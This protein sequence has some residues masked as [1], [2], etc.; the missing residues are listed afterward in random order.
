MTVPPATGG[1]HPFDVGLQPERTALAWRRTA[2]SLAGATVIGVRIVPE[3]AGA[4]T[5][6]PLAIG[7]MLAIAIFAGSHRRYRS[8]HLALTAVDHKRIP[9]SGGALPA[10]VAV[11]VLVLG[12]CAL[13]FV[14]AGLK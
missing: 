12:I 4:W 2:L 5:L 13:A 1:Q 3:Q 10:A 8:D 14:I 6:V 7:L 11:A 9:L